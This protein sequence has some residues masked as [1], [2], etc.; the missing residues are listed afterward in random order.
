M[1][2]LRKS[3]V[4]VLLMATAGPFGLGSG[5]PS[6]ARPGLTRPGSS[7]RPQESP[8]SP[9]TNRLL[10]GKLLY[11]DPGDRR[12]PLQNWLADNLRAWGRYKQTSS[13]EGVDLVVQV[14]KTNSEPQLKANR[15]GVPQPK[16]ER[17]GPAGGV[18]AIVVTDWVT[19]EVLWRADLLNRKGN[20]DEPKLGPETEIY[21]K[22][23]GYDEV[24]AIAIRRLRK[25][26]SQLEAKQ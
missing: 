23:L 7:A 13:P 12:T 22:G 15:E 18:A 16:N 5:S 10:T 11:L 26:V 2:L 4:L 21:A 1:T 3:T 9:G 6:L 25:Y 14:E 24:A 17:K 8:A 19:G 20:N